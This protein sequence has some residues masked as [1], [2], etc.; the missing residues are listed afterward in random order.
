V[1]YGA[2]RAAWFGTPNRY[3]VASSQP[4]E[5]RSKRRRF[6]AFMAQPYKHPQ[7]GIYQLRRKVPHGLREALGREYKRSL[8]T[9]DA[10]EAKARFVLAWAESD[11]AFA[12]ARAQIAGVA[13][14][15]RADARQLAGRWFLAE[16]ERMDQIGDFT[17]ALASEST[18]SVEEGDFREEHAVHE[19]LR[20]VADRAGDFSVLRRTV[21]D[22]LERA[23]R[24]ERLPIP[25]KDSTAY[26]GLF[27]AFEEHLDRLSA[28][29]F[30]R[31]Y[32]EPVVRGVGVAPWAPIEAERRA[33]AAAKPK[34]HT[35]RDLFKRYA[36]KKTLDDGDNRATKKTLAEYNAR[37][38]DF[39]EL[40]G[41]LDVREVSRDLIAAHRV[42]LAK[43]PAKGEGIRGLMAPQLIEKADR[44]GLP[45]LSAPTIRNRLRAL[46]AVLSHGK[47]IG[48]IDENPVIASG[49]ASDAARAAGRQEKRARRRKGYSVDELRTIFASPVFTDAKW[50]PPY[51]DFGRAW[52]WLPLL[53]YYTGARR[54]ELAQLA[55]ADVKRDSAAGLYLSILEHDDEDGQRTVKTEGSRRRIP[56]HPDLLARGF[57]DYVQGLPKDGRL[58]PNLRPDSKGFHGAN[59]GRRWTAYLRDTVKLNSPARPSHGF[60]HTFIT[61]CRDVGIPE[62]VRDAITGHSAGGKVSR[63]Y[64]EMPLTRMAEEIRRYPGVPLP[65]A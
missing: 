50:S 27:N 59:F 36:A 8:D 16:Q 9:R 23:M 65:A 39:I 2:S 53:L 35:L 13:T 64:G 61:A 28:W 43:M 49:V 57:I 51:A 10:N 31:H 32:G 44:E 21:H 62:E 56:L 11:R 63:D 18:V 15:S 4:T 42:L 24:K 19:T 46:S 37:L 38:E 41:N 5:H 58:F 3:T 26:Q 25:P 40:H 52:Y 47:Q 6:R 12:L 22:R 20:A 60:R 7:S 33:D 29:A 55:V 14:Y 17:S 30:E 54:E 48:W 34:V 1:L 45:R